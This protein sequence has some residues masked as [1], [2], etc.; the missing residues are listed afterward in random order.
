MILPMVLA[1]SGLGRPIHTCVLIQA[2]Q[3]KL[4]VVAIDRS[5]GLLNSLVKSKIQFTFPFFL[6][7]RV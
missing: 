2:K 3:Q 6:L 7:C 5:V 1:C 4:E